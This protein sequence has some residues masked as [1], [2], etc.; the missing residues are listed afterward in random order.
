MVSQ[1]KVQRRSVTA[2]DIDRDGN[3][4]IISGLKAGETVVTAGVNS[5]KDGAQVNVLPGKSATNP[6]NLL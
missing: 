5:L 1:G 4:R 3:A 2:D 6:G